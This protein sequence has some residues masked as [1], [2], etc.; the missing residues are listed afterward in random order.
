MAL[1]KAKKVASV[2]GFSGAANSQ[3]REPQGTTHYRTEGAIAM[4]P[5]DTD[6]KQRAEAAQANMS[7]AWMGAI[8]LAILSSIALVV[9]KWF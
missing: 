9:T 6:L 4:E 8:A 1:E 2:L 7:A 3:Q 5:K